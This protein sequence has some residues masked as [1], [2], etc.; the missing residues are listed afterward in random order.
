MKIKF[1]FKG[2]FSDSQ[3]VAAH[4]CFFPSFC[5]NL[6]IPLIPNVHHVVGRLFK[7]KIGKISFGKI[8]LNVYTHK[9]TVEFTMAFHLM[10]SLTTVYSTHDEIH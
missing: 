6:S 8:L 5:E 7:D 1:F 9:V 3:G 10:N 4:I 2:S